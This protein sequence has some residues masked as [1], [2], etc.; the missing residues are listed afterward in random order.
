MV[1]AAVSTLPATVLC[2]NRLFHERAVSVITARSTPSSKCLRTHRWRFPI[3]SNSTQARLNGLGMSAGRLEYR[4][5]KAR[6][7]WSG[8]KQSADPA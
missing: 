6:S 4:L 3:R 2:P 5:P 8:A 1:M 7:E